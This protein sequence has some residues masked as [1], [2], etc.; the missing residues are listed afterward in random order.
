M[1]STVQKN[2]LG[3]LSRGSSFVRLWDIS[4]EDTDKLLD[5]KFSSKYYRGYKGKMNIKMKLN[6]I[7]I[8]CGEPISSF[9]I[10]PTWPR[11]ILTANFNDSVKIV[12]YKQS[13]N[14]G[15]SPHGDIG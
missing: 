2:V 15:L 7:A 5:Y 6:E 4:E 9:G 3:S 12:T 11:C 8:H 13:P 14:F 10:H 1:W